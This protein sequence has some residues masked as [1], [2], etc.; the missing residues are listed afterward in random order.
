MAAGVLTLLTLGG[1]IWA[2]RERPR[3][4]AVEASLRVIPL[5]GGAERPEAEISGLAWYR[6]T[7]VM[8]PQYPERFATDESELSLLTL[9][10]ARIE[11]FLDGRAEG[12]LEVGRVPLVAPGLEAQI[13]EFDGFEAIAFAAD[14]VFVTIESHRDREGTVGWLVG[15]RVEGELDRIVLEPAGRVRLRSQNDL[16]NIGYEALVVR[17][18]ELLVIYETNGE[19]NARPTALVFDLDL[20]PLREER[21]SPIEYRVTDATEADRRGR[22]WVANYHWPGAVWQTATCPLTE[23]HG[24]GP[25]HARC[26]T[27]ERL[28]ELVVTADGVAVTRRAPIQLELVDDDH[29]R[30]WEGLVRLPGRGFLLATDEHPASLLG[31]VPAEV[32]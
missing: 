13:P 25:T 7:L 4:D 30:N 14:R 29:A 5:V 32:D 28:V 15:G 10:R 23:E 18:S 16:P 26:D 11:A 2:L 27:V 9:R 8:L 6:R 12:P 24:Q 21:M 19:V 20:R 1:L 31:F 3:P 17:G 22:F